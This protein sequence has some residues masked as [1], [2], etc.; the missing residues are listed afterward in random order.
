VTESPDTG[1]AEFLKLLEQVNLK[2]IAD[3]LR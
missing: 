2:A 1:D 3:K